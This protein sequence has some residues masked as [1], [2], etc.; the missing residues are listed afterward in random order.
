MSYKAEKFGQK[1]RSG[2]L[3]VL[4]MKIPTFI[5]SLF[6]FFKAV[7]VNPWRKGVKPVRPRR[8][9]RAKVNPGKEE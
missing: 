2:K 8:V 3:K 9:N 4:D 7:T 1:K 5:F 6:R